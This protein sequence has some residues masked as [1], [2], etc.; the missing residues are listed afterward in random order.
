MALPTLHD[1]NVTYSGNNM[2]PCTLA[3][4]TITLTFNSVYEQ[5]DV[6]QVRDS[7]LSSG[8]TRLN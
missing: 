4:N 2:H 7:K 1:V 3:G 6:P 8:H 5:D